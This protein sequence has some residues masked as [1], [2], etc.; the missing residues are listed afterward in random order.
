MNM[1]EETK[2]P[3]AKAKGYKLAEGGRIDIPSLGIKV[4]DEDL[5]NPNIVAMIARKCPGLFGT[6]II[7]A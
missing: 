5:K 4:T 3:V 6:A 7:P 1:A 2:A